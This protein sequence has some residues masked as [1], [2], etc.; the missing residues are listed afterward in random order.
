AVAGRRRS[1]EVLV[2]PPGCRRR[3]LRRAPLLVPRQRREGAPVAHA[4]ARVCPRRAVARALVRRGLLVPAVSLPGPGAGRAR[5]G[6]AFRRY[7][8]GD[9][10]GPAWGWGRELG[11]RLSQGGGPAGA[12]GLQRISAGRCPRRRGR[13]PLASA[14][15]H[16]TSIV[17]PFLGSCFFFCASF[18]YL[19]LLG[20]ACQ[21]GDAYGTCVR[22]CFVSFCFV[23]CVVFDE[24]LVVCS[25]VSLICMIRLIHCFRNGDHGWLIGC[26]SILMY[27]TTQRHGTIYR[28]KMMVKIYLS[29]RRA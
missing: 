23:L 18:A 17:I 15:A 13:G 8:L 10:E 9:R 12:P 7:L 6:A 25:S 21:K 26:A 14:S 2:A 28:L 4:V 24:F 3:P 16:P 22:F 29:G 1:T 19:V 27:T 5:A 11:G 20:S